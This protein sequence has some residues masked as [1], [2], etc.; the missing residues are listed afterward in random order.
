MSS[1]LEHLQTERG[2]VRLGEL[3]ADI[4][5]K[6]GDPDFPKSP[7]ELRTQLDALVTAGVVRCFERDQEEWVEIRP[8]G[9]PQPVE[10]TL[11]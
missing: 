2:A 9:M 7:G 5:A 6:R 11:F 1:L 4:R 8:A 3:L 10:K